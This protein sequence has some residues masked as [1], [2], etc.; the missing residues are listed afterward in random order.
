MLFKCG[1]PFAIAALSCVSIYSIFTLLVTQWRIKHRLEMNAS[2]N[3]AG[4]RIIDSL[5][6]YETVKVNLII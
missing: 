1:P 3:E 6:N 4:A 5:M 2:D